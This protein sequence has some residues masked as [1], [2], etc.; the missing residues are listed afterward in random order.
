MISGQINSNIEAVISVPIRDDDGQICTCQAVIDTG[1]SG[2]LTLPL[3]LVSTLQLPIIETRAFTLGD[4][5][6]VD[7]DLYSAI[8]VWDGDVREILALASEAFPLVGMSLLKGFHLSMDIIDGGE[9]SLVS[10]L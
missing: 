1:F 6:R 5:Q 7:F 8:I 10:R 3:S 2:Y 4:N 9:V